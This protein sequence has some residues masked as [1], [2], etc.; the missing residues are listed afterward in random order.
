MKKLLLSVSAVLFTVNI[1]AQPVAH[2]VTL[3]GSTSINGALLPVSSSLS[4]Y[5]SGNSPLFFNLVS[6][7]NGSTIINP[8]DGSFMFSPTSL[9]ASFLY[10]VTDRDGLISDVAKVDIVPGPSMNIGADESEP[11]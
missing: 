5:V 10:N 1:L 6:Q 2:N 11:G 8:N 9:P 7:T 3:V 4:S